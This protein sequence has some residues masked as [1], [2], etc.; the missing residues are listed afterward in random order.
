MT[1]HA[2]CP[3]KRRVLTSGTGCQGTYSSIPRDKGGFKLRCDTVRK[4]MV[5]VRQP[6]EEA[7]TALVVERC[8]GLLVAPGKNVR[9]GDMTLLEMVSGS[10]ARSLGGVGC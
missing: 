3:R 10:C 4:V 2:G 9:H 8:F 5:S 6:T 7:T 1:C